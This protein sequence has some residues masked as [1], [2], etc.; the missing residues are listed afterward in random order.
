MKRFNK[1]CALIVLTCVQA[2]SSYN[3]LTCPPV[4]YYN[5]ACTSVSTGVCSQ[6]DACP[7]EYSRSG[8]TGQES[9]TCIKGVNGFV[10]LIDTDDTKIR[11]MDLVTSNVTSINMTEIGHITGIKVSCDG[12]YAVYTLSSDNVVM[13]VDLST[14]VRTLVAGSSSSGYT[15]GIGSNA[16]FSGPSGIEIS[17]DCTYVFVAD[18]LNHVIRKIVLAN[19]SVT[20]IAGGGFGGYGNTD[21]PALSSTMYVPTGLGLSPDGSYILIAEG[22]RIR[23]LTLSPS[24]DGLVVTTLA[25]DSSTLSGARGAENGPGPIARFSRPVDVDVSSD[26]EFALVADKDNFMIRKINMSTGYVSTLA[27]TGPNDVSRGISLLAHN[28][29]AIFPMGNV[30]QFY[31]VDTS[32]GIMTAFAG[33]GVRGIKDDKANLATFRYPILTAVWECRIQNSG[34]YMSYDVCGQCPENTFGKGDGTCKPCPACTLG[35]VVLQACTSVS[36]TVCTCPVGYYE[37]G[38]AGCKLCPPGTFTTSHGQTQCLGCPIGTYSPNAINHNTYCNNCTLGVNMPLR[39]AIIK[40]TT[41]NTQCDWECYPPPQYASVPANAGSLSCDWQCNAGYTPNAGGTGCVDSAAPIQV[42]TSAGP[43]PATSTT[44]ASPALTTSTAV[45]GP[46]PTTST[47]SASPALTTSTAAAGPTTT[48]STTSASPAPTTSTAAAGPAPTTSTAAAGPALTTSTAS[49]KVTTS[50]AQ[51][52]SSA[53]S[54]LTT[55]T[56]SVQSTAAAT[57]GAALTTSVAPLASTSAHQSTTTAAPMATSISSAGSS[58]AYVPVTTSISSAGSSAAY[59]PPPTSSST[60][61]A[62]LPPT[63]STILFQ[64]RVAVLAGTPDLAARY[65]GIIADMIPSTSPRSVRAAFQ[66]AQQAR[67][68][69]LL[70]A[71]AILVVT[72][73]VF[74]S[75][76]ATTVTALLKSVNFQD[77]LSS[78]CQSASPV[79]ASAVVLLDTFTFSYA[80]SQT[81]A[82]TTAPASAP[83]RL[84]P[85]TAPAAAPAPS[86]L[87]LQIISVQP[88]G[89]QRNSTPLRALCCGCGTL[90]LAVLLVLLI[91]PK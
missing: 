77:R 70:T 19:N 28:N 18:D 65:V 69:R 55:P 78:A 58:A 46:T 63:L 73:E 45:A 12:T 91:S 64:I 86:G 9:G 61:T 39:Y 42:T 5:G 66:Q 37:T 52:T 13:K 43:T 48:K 59:A 62:M 83:S 25:G 14:G 17:R 29:Y 80:S 2:A 31:S 54:A 71:E 89:A 30:K 81:S 76:D 75:I 85:S 6:C 23:K 21:G 53:S 10:L 50:V 26:G 1:C 34:F 84:P 8:C 20:T 41:N 47:T 22:Y 79:L 3:C 74:G 49:P 57:T 11:K 56:S 7:S 87:P 4:G 88:S 32:S 27:Y 35:T 82:G 36:D 33:S 24:G 72:V 51:S 15:D 90:A 16:L 67:R 44:S 60:A 38:V 40:Q 68:R